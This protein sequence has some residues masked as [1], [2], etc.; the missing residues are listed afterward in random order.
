MMDWRLVYTYVFLLLQEYL[1]YWYVYLLLCLPARMFDTCRKEVPVAIDDQIKYIWI[2]SVR[3][4]LESSPKQFTTEFIS[5]TQLLL[6]ANEQGHISFN[7]LQLYY[8]DLDVLYISYLDMSHR[9]LTPDNPFVLAV[10]EGLT[11][12]V[13][14]KV[15]DIKKRMDIHSGTKCKFGRIQL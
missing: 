9:I 7:T 8:P 2:M 12:G 11:L 6:L 1:Q 3:L 4:T 15:V 13:V 14:T 5:G 10:G